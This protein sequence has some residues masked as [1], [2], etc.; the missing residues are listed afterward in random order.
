MSSLVPTTPGVAHVVDLTVHPPEQLRT[1]VQREAWFEIRAIAEGA[2]NEDRAQAARLIARAKAGPHPSVE[3]VTLTPGMAA[4]LFM[5][6]N[7][8]NRPMDIARARGYAADLRRGHFMAHHQGIGFYADGVLGDGQHR[9]FAIAISK[10]TFDM[11]V[12][13]GLL[14]RAVEVIDQPKQRNLGEY[15][16]LQG[17]PEARI[18]SQLATEAMKWPYL[19]PGSRV[20]RF[21]NME[22]EEWVR[23]HQRELDRAI[24]IAKKTTE[25][26]GD[27]ILP[28]K[29]AAYV[30][31]GLILAGMREAEIITFVSELQV[32]AA[33]FPNAPPQMLWQIL[34]RASKKRQ[35]DRK[36]VTEKVALSIKAA[37]HWQKHQS[38]AKLSWLGARK[39]HFPS[40]TESTDEP[41]GPSSSESVN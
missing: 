13:F 24:Q 4:V 16:T 31:L 5:E 20:P 1:K 11:P 12:Y 14:K 22:R 37:K 2:S 3:I 18:K 27:V 23:E 32:G 8:F 6:S 7:S 40:L 33:S 26:E 38:V 9:L 17:V 29:E 41:I 34:E 25:A 28:E 15:L 39:E 21:N 35:T 36:T 30:A 10:Q 19:A